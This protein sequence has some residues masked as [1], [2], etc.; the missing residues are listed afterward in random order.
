MLL[1]DLAQCVRTSLLPGETL[2]WSTF[3][4]AV[5]HHFPN[6]FWNCPSELQHMFIHLWIICEIYMSILKWTKLNM[7]K[8]SG[9]YKHFPTWNCRIW[10]CGVHD[11]KEVHKNSWQR[12]C[13]GTSEQATARVIHSHTA[14]KEGGLSHHLY[15]SWCQRELLFRTL[16]NLDFR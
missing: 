4:E 3:Q 8:H 10:F 9:K 6:V 5:R 15:A 16:G 12:R 14:F 11:T 1:P 2:R 13:P 7:G